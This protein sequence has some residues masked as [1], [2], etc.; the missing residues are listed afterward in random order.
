MEEIKI[1]NSDYSRKQMEEGDIG[2]SIGDSTNHF[3]N[4]IKQYED[5]GYTIKFEKSIW[6]MIFG[7]A[8]YKVMAIKEK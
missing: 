5:D 1:G 4:T 6:R 2:W 7:P 8:I 3:L